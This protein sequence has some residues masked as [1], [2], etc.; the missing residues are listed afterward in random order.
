[1]TIPFNHVLALPRFDIS[2]TLGPSCDVA[3][4]LHQDVVN[5]VLDTIHKA[6][7]DGLFKGSFR[8]D[9]QT[10][11]KVD[12]DLTLPP[13]LTFSESGE[14]NERLAAQVERDTPGI[15]GQSGVGAALKGLRNLTLEIAVRGVRLS[16]SG[17]RGKQISP[18]TISLDCILYA[19][20]TLSNDGQL[21]IVPFD[22]K[23]AAG[24]G[25]KAGKYE[26][27]IFALIDMFVPDLLIGKLTPIL[28]DALSAHVLDIPEV[29]GVAL[30]LQQLFFQNGFLVF[31][32]TMKKR[33]DE[34]ARLELRSALSGGVFA[35]A[36]YA[37]ANAIG[38][39]TIAAMVGKWGGQKS[40]HWTIFSW[41]IGFSAWAG[42]L[43]LTAP[44]KDWGVIRI[45]I[46][47]MAQLHL[48]AKA[49]FLKA[50]LDGALTDTSAV[51]FDA[52]LKIK[53]TRSPTETV[54]ALYQVD[55]V[56]GEEEFS[57]L[58][59]DWNSNIPGLAGLLN[60]FSKGLIALLDL[61][62]IFKAKFTAPLVRDLAL[63]KVLPVATATFV[64]SL[65]DPAITS[66]KTG[67]LFT[68]GMTFKPGAIPN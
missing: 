25:G 53:Q 18:V 12:W 26:T 20:V 21:R 24:G 37:A 67:V 6:L 48:V 11:I 57:G 41:G 44:A 2:K 3:V 15:F 27:F 46:A 54:P 56:I 68:A 16:F 52:G 9:K 39:N 10:G 22:V 40:D 50:R 23:I 61:A 19:Y 29:Q 1:M 33:R 32:A 4:G 5:T 58:G 66:A 28:N 55:L 47:L 8:D 17:G 49:L 64:T 65:T 13:V 7:H 59:I 45:R 51:G 35:Y 43:A 60:V 36:S 34:P 38:S 14:G 63:S 42:D 31:A 30:G 62:T